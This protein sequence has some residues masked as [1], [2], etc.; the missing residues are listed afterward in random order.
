MDSST[1]DSTF[2]P[3]T[4]DFASRRE[5]E[6]QALVA[7]ARENGAVEGLV[8]AGRS[9]LDG[10]KEAFDNALKTGKEPQISGTS[11]LG[12]RISGFFD[13]SVEGVELASNAIEHGITQPLDRANE[14]MKEALLKDADQIV[15]YARENISQ[16][17]RELE[18]AR[19]LKPELASSIE[20]AI[21]EQ[22][23]AASKALQQKEVIQNYKPVDEHPNEGLYHNGV[24]GEFVARWDGMTNIG[25]STVERFR[26]GSDL[27]E[28][29]ESTLSA[30]RLVEG[31]SKELVRAA[32]E[33]PDRLVIYEE[34]LSRGSE[35][36]VDVGTPSDAKQDLETVR[37]PASVHEPGAAAKN[38]ALMDK[39]AVEATAPAGSDERL[40]AFHAS[41][42]ESPRTLLND[43]P[44]E[45]D[46]RA[47]V[48]DDRLAAFR[49]GPDPPSAG[50]SPNREQ[51]VHPIESPMNQPSKSK[52][53]S[54]DRPEIP[55]PP[56]P[57]PPDSGS[58]G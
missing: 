58:R 8:Q 47:G 32:Q 28:V 20:A 31:Y 1:P 11:D 35:T 53:E 44:V 54:K 43:A 27:R 12:D 4:A 3:G 16:L 24:L 52:S 57:P 51:G 42:P 2:L 25:R 40:A 55:P 6:R 37:A 34:R 10:G 9:F 7:Q 33:H 49:E 36:K 18:A 39:S 23:I 45:G 19:T 30:G 14:I 17:N 46:T 15:T 21:R 38:D 56:P 48:G 29:E 26:Q 13:R 22:E 50:N 41:G 5:A